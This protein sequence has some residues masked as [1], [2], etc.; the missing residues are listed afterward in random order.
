MAQESSSE[1]PESSS[2]SCSVQTQS[3]PSLFR[4]TSFSR[5]N[6][7]APE[8]VPNRPSP[9]TDLQQPRLVV[10]PPPPPPTGVLHVYPPPPVSPFQIPIQSHMPVASQCVPVQNHNH[11]QHHIPV[12]FRIHSHQHQHYVSGSGGGF[13]QQDGS[14]QV[15]LG[16]GPCS[17]IKLSEESTQKILNQV[18]Y[19]FSDLNLA[20]TDH[21]MRFI[22]KDPEG[23]V[24]ISVV[25]SFKK[26]KALISSYSQLATVLRNSSKLVVSEDRQKVKRKHPLTE[27]DLEDLQS[28]V[29]IAENLPE[30][31][32]HQNLM[33]VFSAVGSVK[34]I[35]TCPPQTSNSGA[36]VSKA[37]KT[38][39]VF[40]N[41][42]HA[43][44]EY[45]S[46]ELAEK[47]VA[48]LN[49]EGN[50]R[51]SLRIR[52]MFRRMPKSA[53]GRGKKGHDVEA[54]CEEE[55]TSAFEH[56]ANEKQLEDPSWPEVNLHDHLQGEDHCYEEGGQKK[57]RNRG[58][59][60]GRGRAQYH[61]NNGNHMRTPL[62]SYSIN[63]ELA[64]PKQP[65]PPGPRMPDGTRGFVMG[66]GKPVA[67]DIA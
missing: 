65:Q 40:S 52:L 6:A 39:G 53:Q 50:W 37:A 4:S 35:R 34:C 42:L 29:I 24:P 60:K 21:L 46:V 1:A 43:F 38:D 64:V 26:I 54:N 41:K 16:H 49:D 32:C 7:Q 20:T 48:E 30:D 23:Y 2:S 22:N 51:S 45:G 25:A 19:Y 56:H 27:S 36:T 8:F 61:N 63:S 47:A 66:R 44:V 11:H 57:G 12:E 67:V 3:C 15:D 62:S 17:K 10:P 59:G 5:L 14:M 58:C 28:R 18:E 33:K 55:D 31:H 13:G 9:R